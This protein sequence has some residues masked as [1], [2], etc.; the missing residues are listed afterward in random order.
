GA[1]INPGL[2]EFELVE[3]FLPLQ[4]KSYNEDWIKTWSTKWTIDKNDL[5]RLRNH[6]GEKIAYYFAFLQFYFTWLVIPSIAGLVTHFSG[7]KYSIPFSIFIT[8]WSVIFVEF[9]RRK[10][11]ELAV[12]WGVRH[13]S[14]VERRRPEFRAECFIKN[15]ITGEEV[16]YFS[17]WKRWLRRAV[18]AP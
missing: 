13:F 18:V 7:A 5:L 12:D 4:D 6:F 3:D 9:W 14:R 11:Y 15:P 8:L 1:G 16:P 10:E 2:K 17:P